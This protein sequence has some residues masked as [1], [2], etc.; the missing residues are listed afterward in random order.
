MSSSSDTLNGSHQRE[1]LF[2]LGNSYSLGLQDLRPL[3]GRNTIG[4]NRVLRHPLAVSGQFPKYLLLVDRTVVEAEAQR[5]SA[6]AGKVVAF[7]AIEGAL[8]NLDVTP[9]TFGLRTSSGWTLTGDMELSS[10]TSV[11]AVQLARRMGA[12]K[13]V[14]LGVDLSGYSRKDSHFF[15]DGKREGCKLTQN[16]L[17]K[18]LDN[19][20][21]FVVR[22]ESEGIQV[23][24]ASPVRGPMDSVMP[25]QPFKEALSGV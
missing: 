9:F 16:S 15:G 13:I 2:V 8:R 10:N 3:L 17:E 11:Y 12:A 5:I 18:V 25:R 23:V 22:C 19:L 6:F 7:R 1:T 21:C 4:V 24:N 14:L 20:G